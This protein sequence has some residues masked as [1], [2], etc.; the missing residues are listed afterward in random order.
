MNNIRHQAKKFRMVAVALTML[1][2]L[3]A[4]TVQPAEAQTYSQLSSFQGQV[5]GDWYPT[6]H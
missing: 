1:A 3:F 4:G 6:G 2:L 5:Y